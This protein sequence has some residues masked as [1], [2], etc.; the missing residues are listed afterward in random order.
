MLDPQ[1]LFVPPSLSALQAMYSIE[2]GGAQ[3]A[4]VV[5][6]QGILL[7]TLTD[8]DIRRGLLNGQRL[9][10][11]VDLMMNRNFRFIYNTE[12]ELHGLN[13]M[14]QDQLLQMPILDSK[15]C[16]V[17]V[18]L[19]DDLNKQKILPNTAVIMAGGLGTRLRPFTDNC[20]KP[21]LPIHGKPMLE[22]LLDQ[23]ISSGFR[24]FYFSVNYLKDNIINYFGDGEAWNVEINYLIEEA[25]LG[26]AGSLALLPTNIECPLLVMNGDVLTRLN[27][28]QLLDFHTAYESSS[29]I[30]VRE[31]ITTLPFGVVEANGADLVGFKEKPSYTQLINTGIYI[32]EP[33]ILSM[34]S[35]NT[36]LDMP[37]LLESVRIAGKR[38]TIYP[39]HE[40]WI[41]VG[42]PESLQKAY[43]EWS[44]GE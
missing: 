20:P 42:T 12:D 24:K 26:T 32:I 15:G 3:L 35:P 38:V 33:S 34:L 30:C 25:P 11:T 7:G 17:K 22:I 19:L 27:L 21:M 18:L 9:D 16:V 8:G 4:L 2:T 44:S 5:D 10:S 41:D 1:K 36:A 39:L 28:K 29:T 6:E 43:Q 23:C 31:H 13:L 37:A 40:P 14:R